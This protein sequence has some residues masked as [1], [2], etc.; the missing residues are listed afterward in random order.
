[1]EIKIKT[2]I[3][4]VLKQS[5]LTTQLDAIYQIAEWDPRFGDF[6]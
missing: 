4:T 6:K 2:D 1:M 3:K 5:P